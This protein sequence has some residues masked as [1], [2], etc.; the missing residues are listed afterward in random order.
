MRIEVLLFT[1]TVAIVVANASHAAS[2]DQPGIVAS[3]FV[4]EKAP[5]DQCHASTIAS[6]GEGL[7][8]AWFGGPREGDNE[9]G[10]WV[11]RHGKDGWSDPVEVANGVQTDGKRHPCWNPVLFQTKGGPLVL[12]Y[13]VG[14]SP[15]AWWGMVTTSGDAGKTWSDGRRLPDGYVGP[16][17]NK[18]IQL[19][20]G[21]LLCGSSTEH[22][23]WRVHFE[24]AWDHGRQRQRIGP[25]NDGRQFDAIQ[26]TMLVH[27]GGRI[28]ALC[29][30]R[31][32]RITQ[33]FSDDNGRTWGEMT[34]TELPNPNS[35]IDGVT[36]RDGRHLLVYNH[37][38]RSGP[39]PRGREMLNVAV[40][41]DGEQW[42]AALVLENESGEFSYPAVIQTADG[43]VHVTYT[44][45][46][47]RVKHVVIDP[48]KLVLRDM[49]DGKWPQ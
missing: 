48:A 46:R 44:W 49:P 11:A 26:P 34:A 28:Q 35:G 33:V 14:P 18:P 45:K 39:G 40:S 23:G 17:K 19:P 13:K 8:A 22:D 3:E 38:T 24:L 12:F 29:R 6:S 20:D 1:I 9:V 37:T 41:R 42:K 2:D 43:Q 16:I 25:V 30:S 10:I 27:S 31:Q 32:G 21:K 15:R 47:T 36:L 4:Y 5:F 7:V